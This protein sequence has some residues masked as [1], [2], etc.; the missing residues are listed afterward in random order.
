ME[1]DM[2]SIS[3]YN[4]CLLKQENR[5]FNTSVNAIELVCSKKNS[6]INFFVLILSRQNCRWWLMLAHHHALGMIIHIVCVYI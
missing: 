1:I 3:I 2:M 4:I 5:A 6:S